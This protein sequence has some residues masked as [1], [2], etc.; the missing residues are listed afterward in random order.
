[1]LMP[2][3]PVYEESNPPWSKDDIRLPRKVLGVKAISQASVVER[4]P[5]SHFRLGIPRADARHLF[6]SS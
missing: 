4:A 1:M 2:K 6:A 5:D 3:A